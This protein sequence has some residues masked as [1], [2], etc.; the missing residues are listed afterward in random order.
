[1][2]GLF[3][4]VSATDPQT[5]QILYRPMHYELPTEHLL[6]WIVPH[7]AT[8]V[9]VELHRIPSDDVLFMMPTD[10]P[11]TDAALRVTDPIASP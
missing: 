4:E 1:V 6:Q 11:I 7:R 3:L 2:S 8:I 9:D 10:S 5:D